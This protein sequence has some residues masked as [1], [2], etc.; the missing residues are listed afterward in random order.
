M[1]GLWAS[2]DTMP[3]FRLF[4]NGETSVERGIRRVVEGEAPKTMMRDEKT[5]MVNVDEAEN[6]TCHNDRLDV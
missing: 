6:Q 2:L 5:K 4:F 1:S 3:I